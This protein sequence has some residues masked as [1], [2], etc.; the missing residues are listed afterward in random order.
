[1]AKHEIVIH[2]NT[3]ATKEVAPYL[4]NYVG[5]ETVKETGFIGVIAQKSG[6]PAIQAQAILDGSFE[7]IDE[8]EREGLVRIHTD[9]GTI[10][11][12]ITGSFETADAAFDPEKNSFELALHLIDEIKFALA[13]VVPTIIA[14]ENLTKLRVDNI[15]DVA[16]PRPYNLIHGQAI[17]KVAGY[18][19]ELSDEGATVYLQDAKGVTYE[20]VVDEVISKQLFKGH[21]AALLEG[22][23]YKLIVKSRAGDAGGPLQT[24]FRKVKY[25]KVGTP[26]DPTAPKLTGFSVDRNPVEKIPAGACFTVNGERLEA[27]NCDTGTSKATM[28]FTAGPRAGTT[29]ELDYSVISSSPRYDSTMG[30]V[31][32]ATPNVE[33]DAGEAGTLTLEIDGKTS[34]ALAFEVG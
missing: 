32:I 12:V 15:M 25:L 34:N 11:G 22:G 7:A 23:D 6:L 33:L 30:G 5:K 4:G 16:T 3:G 13:D 19:M 18:N 1:M 8:L 17:F 29:L 24:A 14:D 21:S 31:Y 2:E 9:I 10:C 28:A 20:V 26:V 27:F